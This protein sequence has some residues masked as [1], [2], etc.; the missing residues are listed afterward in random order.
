M[1]KI[2]IREL[3]RHGLHATSLDQLLLR[4]RA[5]RGLDV[6]Y[7]RA[8]ARKEAFERIYRQ[9]IWLV[10]PNRDCL[11]GAGSRLEATAVLQ[12]ELPKM[13]A[14]LGADSLL[15]VGCGDFTWMQHVQLGVPYLGVDIVESVIE[16]NR[17]RHGSPLREFRCVDAV[18]EPL[19]AADVV[20]CREVLFHLSLAD[21]TSLLSNVRASGARYLIATTDEATAFNADIRS[22]DF[23][24][25]NLRKRPFHLPAPMYEIRDDAV[26]HGR[27]MGV[28]RVADR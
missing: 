15:D 4:R 2:T 10:G 5:S 17:R 13:I 1:N 26:Q 27:V 8:G 28:W 18:T 20:L 3:V 23:R 14:Q 12:A 7:L 19:P 24:V 16:E 6:S 25:L 9:G 22:G 21:A 11:S